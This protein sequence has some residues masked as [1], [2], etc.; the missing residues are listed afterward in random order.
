VKNGST[1]RR[2]EIVDIA[3]T[4]ATMLGISYPSATTGKPLNWMME[5]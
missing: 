2:S 1:S 5:D 3:P 4:I